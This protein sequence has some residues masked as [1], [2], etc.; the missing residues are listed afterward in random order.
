MLY[1]DIVFLLTYCAHI[2]LITLTSHIMG[3]NLSR[4][5]CHFISILLSVVTISEALI[6]FA[7]FRLVQ[8]LVSLLCLGW[9]F[10]SPSKRLIIRRFLALTLVSCFFAGALLLIQ[11]QITVSVPLLL[12]LLIINYYVGVRFYQQAVCRKIHT[13]QMYDITV[14]LNQQTIQFKAFFDTGHQL[15]DP[16]TH[17][18]VLFIDPM[19][20]NQFNMP[21]K[22]TNDAIKK[23]L[24]YQDIN[25]NVQAMTC[26]KPERVCICDHG[27]LKEVSHVLLGLRQH[28]FREEEGFQA[29]FGPQLLTLLK[30]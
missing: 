16:I 3:V 9:L 29:L 18:S 25:A 19:I 6:T 2:L 14:T 28:N 1:V 10:Y 4:V 22:Q 11:S 21:L 30:S 12:L 13:N 7:H 24:Y 5:K 27:E 15:I 8:L 17:D 23:Q 26:I 20:F